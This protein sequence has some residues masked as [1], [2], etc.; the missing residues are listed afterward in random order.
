MLQTQQQMLWLVA[1]GKGLPLF[2]VEGG[3][4]ASSLNLTL[5]AQAEAELMPLECWDGTQLHG[6][7]SIGPRCRPLCAAAAPCCAR[8]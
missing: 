4:K 5:L 1:C 6:G 8:P 3:A 7:R 2:M